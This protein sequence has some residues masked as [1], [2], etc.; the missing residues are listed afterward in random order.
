MGPLSVPD[1]VMTAPLLLQL[2]ADTWLHVRES[3]IAFNKKSGVV[4]CTN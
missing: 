3:E 2:C 1:C 4:R